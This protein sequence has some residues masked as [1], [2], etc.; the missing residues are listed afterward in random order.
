MVFLTLLLL[1]A[2]AP[3]PGSFDQVK[4]E[5]NPERR[6]RAAVEFAATAEKK[7]E[8][9]LS[10]GDMKEVVA[11]LKTMQESMEMTRDSLIASRK[12]PGRDPGLYKYVELRSRELLVRLDDLERRL[13]VED[14]ELVAVP[15]TKV[16]EIHDF[17]FDGIAEK[18]EH[19]LIRPSRSLSGRCL[20]VA[21]RFP[22][23]AL[24]RT[25]LV[26]QTV[27]RRRLNWRA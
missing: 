20:I 4:G 21:F 8:A 13:L 12:T 19:H 25:V 14:R 17:W 22:I 16:L 2:A 26:A 3:I 9:A 27:C 5:P 11:D 1:L 24:R 10:N 18:S 23:K 7:A 15:K 6:A